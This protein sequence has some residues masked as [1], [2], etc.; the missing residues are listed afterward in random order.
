MHVPERVTLSGPQGP[1]VCWPRC[2]LS[3]AQ[4]PPAP[5]PDRA[6][7]QVPEIVS[8]LR[9]K[10]QETWEEHVRQA[11]QHSVSLLASQ[12]CEAVVSSLL[13]S[14]LP[15]D[16]YWGCRPSAINGALAQAPGL[17]SVG[18]SCHLPP[19]SASTWEPTGPLGPAQGCCATLGVPWVAPHTLS[20]PRVPVGGLGSPSRDLPSARPGPAFTA[21]LLSPAS[22]PPW[23]GPQAELGKRPRLP[24]HQ[25]VPH[26]HANLEFPPVSGP[27][28]GC[29]RLGHLALPGLLLPF[30]AV[31]IVG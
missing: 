29:S 16:R 3:C 24:H 18:P 14:P 17:G 21:H 12:H 31:P 8:V 28:C 9:S 19:R 7:P 25:C 5:R 30:F 2:L 11:A 10:L 23:P 20:G 22:R 4:G 13:G 27:A 26:S 1:W 6:S 15:F